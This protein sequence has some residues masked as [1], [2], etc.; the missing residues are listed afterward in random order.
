MILIF[1]TP[2]MDS[3]AGTTRYAVDQPEQKM[4]L[5]ISGEMCGDSMSDEVFE[6]KVEVI[7]DGKV[8]HGCGRPLH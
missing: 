8:L 1:L 4:I 7:L 3:L 6:S 5:T 2:E